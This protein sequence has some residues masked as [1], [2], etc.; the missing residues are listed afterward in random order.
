MHSIEGASLLYNYLVLW[1]MFAYKDSDELFG[2][3]TQKFFGIF[4]WSRDDSTSIK[5]LKQAGV[6]HDIK[7]Q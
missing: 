6:A 5:V 2:T 4:N 7:S 3:S 1:H